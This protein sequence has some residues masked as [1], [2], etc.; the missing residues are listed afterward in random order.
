MALRGDSK[1]LDQ[2][3]ASMNRLATGQE[4]RALVRGLGALSKEL[5][6]EGFARGRAPTGRRWPEPQYRR[7][8]AMIRSGRLRKSFTL[9]I[10]ESGFEIAS[11]LHY[12]HILQKGVRGRFKPRLQVPDRG[13]LSARWDKAMRKHAHAWIESVM[14]RPTRAVG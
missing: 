6:D 8:P 12:S 9:R 14:V 13:K 7:G 4:Q 5:V 3:I 10:G 11:P 1:R 2:L